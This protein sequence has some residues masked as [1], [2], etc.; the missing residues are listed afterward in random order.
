MNLKR[1]VVRSENISGEDAKKI[2]PED[3]LSLDEAVAV[4]GVDGK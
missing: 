4:I 3:L 2:L 1:R